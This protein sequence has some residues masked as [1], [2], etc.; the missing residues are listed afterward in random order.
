M[1][2]II[3]S[4]HGRLH[5]A[6]SAFW[7]DKAQV[8]VKLVCGWVPKNPNGCVVSLCSKCV[9]RD[10]SA[11]MAKRK[12][13]MGASGQICSCPIPD[14]LLSGMLYLDQR[15][16]SGRLFGSIAS[17]GWR[18]FG[19]CARKWIRKFSRESDVIVHVRSGAAH[20]GSIKLAKKMHIPVVVDHSIAHPAYMEEHLRGE[21]LKNGVRFE[22][23]TSSPFWRM[24]TEDCNWADVLLVNSEFVKDTFLSQGYPADK[25]KVVYLGTRPDFWGLRKVSAK[26]RGGR[27]LK[28]LF[29]G[30]FS[31]RKG[32]EYLLEGIKIVRAKSKVPF[33]LDVVGSYSESNELIKRFQ[34]YKLP[35]IFHGPV[36]QDDLK[37]YLACSDIYVFP[38]LSEG[39]ACSGMEAMAAGLC[40]I[41]TYESGFPIT[42]GQNGIIVKS[43]NAT[44]IAD[45]I[46]WL[47]DNPAE[48][49][50][51]GAEAASLIR[52]NYTWDQYAESVK[53]I[54]E[55]MVSH[56]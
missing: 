44:E 45:K 8:A 31:F 7:L 15:L 2:S 54:Y 53:S 41:G 30:N 38:S 10:L 55:G 42:D 26:D 34:E 4:G 32:A 56:G 6:Q 36:P 27:K 50:R 12:I 33:E 16:F 23:G 14:F 25:I 17:I 5:F 18:L 52:T 49:D 28:L 9:G 47:M 22:L 51:M 46:L 24:V 37:G 40:V 11:G 1:T 3:L 21:Y 48:I 29:T 39:C 43:K 13:D 35:V 20:G 19:F